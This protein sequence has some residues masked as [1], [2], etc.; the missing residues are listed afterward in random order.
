MHVKLS[1]ASEAL[2]ENKNAR[3]CI[4]HVLEFLSTNIHDDAEIEDLLALGGI[5]HGLSAHVESL[6]QQIERT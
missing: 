4:I 2:R 5:M 6:E 1:E 3:E